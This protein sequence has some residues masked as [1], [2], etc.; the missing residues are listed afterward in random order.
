[1][2]VET[3]IIIFEVKE[4]YSPKTLADAFKANDILVMPISETQVRMVLHLDI[5]E[6]MVND[7]I[8]VIH[9]L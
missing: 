9:I 5:I 6:Q 1:M 4:H 3:N 8:E 2:P 7:T